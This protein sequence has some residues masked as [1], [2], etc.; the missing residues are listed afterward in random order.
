MQAFRDMVKGW[1]GK[2][3]LA[4]IVALMAL[5]GI[6]S[7][8]AGGA[9]PVAAEVNGKEIYKTELDSAVENQ[10][11]QLLARMGEN[12]DPALINNAQ[13]REEVLNELVRRELLNQ[14]AKKEGFLISDQVIARLIQENAAFHDENGK[15]SLQRY[16]QVIRQAGQNPATFPQVA[17]QQI[18]V[19]QLITGLAQSGF[20]T[21]S[22]LNHLAALDN[23]KRDVHVAL[24][25]SADYLA[26]AKIADADIKAYYDKNVKLFRTEEKVAIE[27]VQL[28]KA[29]FL[30]EVSI[31]D[32]DLAAAYDERV[33]AFSETEQR[34]AA[35]ILIGQSDDALKKA[36]SIE[37]RLKAGEDFAALAKEFSEDPG[38]VE[39]G[40]DL[41]FAGRGQFVPEFET[42]L[43]GLKVGEVSAPIK[44]EFGYHLIKLLGVQ[45]SAPPSF[46]SLKAELES[47]LRASKAEEAFSDA[48]ERFDAAAYEAVDLKDPAAQFNLSVQSSDLFGRKGGTG[49][50]ADRKIID[51][52]FS[53][54]VLKEGKNSTSIH[55][56]D[57][58]VVWVR[59]KQHDAERVRPLAEVTGEIR[60]TLTREFAIAEGKKHAEAIVADLAAG[61]SRADVAAAHRVQW[62]DVSAATRTTQFPHPELSSA[63]F[64]VI[65]PQAG[66]TSAEAVLIGA[67]YSVVAVSRV[68]AGESSL[69]AAEQIQMTAILGDGR[70]QQELEDYLEY[71]ESRA[72]VKTFV[73]EEA[74]T[75]E[76]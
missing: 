74:E 26:A 43:Y 75:E 17:K 4:L 40:G 38:S 48:G 19:S 71:L 60:D 7:Y 33:R 66:Q 23:Q 68:E 5:L 39:N 62:I 20:I 45:K 9:N 10:R 64:R 34:H 14:Q 65:A 61:K 67:N 30:A 42:A 50:A 11:R 35:H 54:D 44:T 1:L 27:Y 15:F 51:A 29:P 25:S 47:E 16:E 69:S 24:V 21:K 46:A 37:A 56:D 41:G 72:K 12:A 59:V 70:A 28:Q 13:L 2:V 22:E 18:A 52:A 76:E 57:G 53:D 8:F 6:E 58:S 3:L 55:M 36:Q 73:S 32:D 31:S 49:L 63:A